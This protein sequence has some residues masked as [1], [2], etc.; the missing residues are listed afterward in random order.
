MVT[1]SIATQP[2]NVNFNS[3][4]ACYV[5]FSTQLTGFS[6]TPPA[7]RRHEPPAEAKRQIEMHAVRAIFPTF[8]LDAMSHHSPRAGPSPARKTRC[9]REDC[10]YPHH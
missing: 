3:L 2:R 1:V 8:K 6:V 9:S 7:E 10:R 4:L 5:Q